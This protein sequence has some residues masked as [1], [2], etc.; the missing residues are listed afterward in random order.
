MPVAEWTPLYSNYDHAIV[1]YVHGFSYKGK[2][3]LCVFA[4]PERALSQARLA[5]KKQTG[6]DH[7]LKTIPLP[8][9]S[10]NRI[11]QVFDPDRYVKYDFNREFPIADESAFVHVERPRPE[12]ITYDVSLWTRN[13]KDIDSVYGQIVR[14]LRSDC[15][16]LTVTHPEPFNELSCHTMLTDARNTSVLEPIGEQ[17]TLRRV[18]PFVMDAWICYIPTTV[19]RIEHIEVELWDTDDLETGTDLLDTIHIV[20]EEDD[21]G[22]QETFVYSALEYDLGSYGEGGYG[23]G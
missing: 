15:V 8:I 4:T 13:L 12:K 11:S 16:Y 17:R 1:D 3:I 7:D 5:I 2:P 22:T 9:F 20:G 19:G 10:I 6:V 21:D 23:G 18:F 14:S